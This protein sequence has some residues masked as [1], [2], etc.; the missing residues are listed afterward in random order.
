MNPTTPF[1]VCKEFCAGSVGFDINVMNGTGEN[2]V[3]QG[4]T[5]SNWNASG[6]N[7]TVVD[8]INGR[9]INE[10][11]ELIKLDKSGNVKA[12]AFGDNSVSFGTKSQ[13]L[14]GK[15]FVEGSKNIAFGNNTH[16]EGNGTFAVGQH[17]H[18]EGSG[19]TSIGNSSHSEGRDTVAQ[20]DNSHSE[21]FRTI[22]GGDSQHVQGKWNVVMDDNYA[23]V[24]GNGR[25]DY[26][27]SNAHTL[28]WKGNAWYAGTVETTGIILKSPNGTRFMLTV[29]DTGE[30]ATK[31][32]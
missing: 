23:H 22:T 8:Y 19:T 16:A 27:R 29:S 9:K 30:L 3:V 2:T 5:L 7:A 10:N 4:K 31:A 18:S 24:V 14:G 11:G 6:V 21:G 25:D 15:S 17:S 20:H 26:E 12:G 32:I 13:A 28:D 1:S